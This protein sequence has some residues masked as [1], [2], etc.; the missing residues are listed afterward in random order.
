[1]LDELLEYGGQVLIPVDVAVAELLGRVEG[2]EA[3][4][5]DAVG[6]AGVVEFDTEF[7]R[8]DGI[9]FR[10]QDQDGLADGGEVGLRAGLPDGKI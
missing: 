7:V 2:H 4:G 10:V 5:G 8:H 6:A 3:D 9:V 1:M